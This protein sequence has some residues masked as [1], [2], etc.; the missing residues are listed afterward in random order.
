MNI[1]SRLPDVGTTIFTVM[2][3]LALEHGAINLSQGFPDFP[4]SSELIALVDKFM[5]EAQNQYAPMPGTPVLRQAIA[6]VIRRTYSLTVDAETQVLVTAGA[7]E[8]IFSSIA[9][10]INPGN[11]VILFDAYYDSYAPSI[12]LCG[13]VP[14]HISLHLPEFRIPWDEVEA[15]ISSKTRMIIINTPHNPLGTIL[16]NED[17]MQLESLALKYGLIVISDEVYERLV[18]DGETHQSVLRYP[19][20]ATQSLACY[21]FGKTF[22][23]TGWKVGYVVGPAALVAEVK[24]AHQFIVFSVNTPVQLALAEYL[25]TPANYEGLAPFFQAKR[26]FFLENLKGSSFRPLQ[27]KGSYF[28]LLSYESISTLSDYEMAVDLTKRFKVA[29][30]P[31]SVFYNDRTDAKLLRFCFAKREETL[32]EA[33]KILRTL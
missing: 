7:T 25:R 33:C 18:Y 31:V 10:F 8:A 3:K 30:I 12:R 19:A 15:R 20:L 1:K 4:I 28:Q 27:T 17:L 5:K 16:S 2:S 26:N 29:C 11:E 22:H 9:A 14:V 21:S 23:A 32:F 13:G 6:D 24:K